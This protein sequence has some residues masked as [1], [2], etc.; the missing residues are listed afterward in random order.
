MAL[1]PASPENLERIPIMGGRELELAIETVTDEIMRVKEVSDAIIAPLIYEIE[2]PDTSRN[3]LRDVRLKLWEMQSS[4][5]DELNYL[6][7]QLSEF[8]IATSSSQYIR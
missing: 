4:R 3:R 5:Q 6:T 8:D 7:A 2:N 1:D